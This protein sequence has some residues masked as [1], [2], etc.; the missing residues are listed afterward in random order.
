MPS[1]RIHDRVTLW[2]LPWIAGGAFAVTRSGELTLIITGGF[3]FSGLMF[4]PDLDIYS[5][6]FKRWGKLRWLWIP[7]QKA[8]SH[9]SK[10][11]H[12]F[13]IGTILRVVY[14]GVIVWG[15]SLL[16]IAIA[17]LIWGFAWNWQR[18]VV[19]SWQNFPHYQA[20]AIALF[21]GLELGAMSHSLADWT[22]S[23]HKRIQRKGWKT[24]LPQPKKRKTRRKT[25]TKRQ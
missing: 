3:L 6:Q 11:S 15:V 4:G 22:G 10:L 8:L 16:G 9:R 14:L 20:E 18:V 23:T 19:S 25:L 5:V 21:V 17:Q 2:S 1:G 24:L 7:Y 12:G 13:L